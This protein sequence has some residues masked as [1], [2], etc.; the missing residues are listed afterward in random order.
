M[1]VKEHDRRI[2]LL[3]GPL[4]EVYYQNI[5]FSGSKFKNTFTDELVKIIATIEEEEV[6]TC[7]LD[8]LSG[9]GWFLQKCQ[10]KHLLP[11]SLDITEL[12]CQVDEV[13]IQ[14]TYTDLEDKNFD[15]FYG[16]FG[17]LYYLLSRLEAGISIGSHLNNFYVYLNAYLHKDGYY[18]NKKNPDE[19]ELGLAHGAMAHC[20]I[21][22]KLSAFDHRFGP[23]ADA[24]VEFVLSNKSGASI[25]DVIEKGQP[26]FAP[27]RWCHGELGIGYALL[28][29]GRSEKHT[30]AYAAGVELLA[31]LAK[32][33]DKSIEMKVVCHGSAGMQLVYGKAFEKTGEKYFL[34]ACQKWDEITTNNLDDI[35]LAPNH[36][37]GVLQ[38]HY[39]ILSAKQEALQ[40]YNLIAESI[41]IL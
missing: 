25:P 9:F 38:G 15:F 35:H 29:Y 34:S 17:H 26:L 23:L 28:T 39:G 33:N 37:P 6:S 40:Q 10:S 22:S 19:V 20:L 11:H 2:G 4:A 36:F 41:L 1:T 13:I 16:A 24:I 21:L 8:G 31:E 3:S 27:I 18:E 14:S 7:Y 30:R 5:L 32:Q 12:L